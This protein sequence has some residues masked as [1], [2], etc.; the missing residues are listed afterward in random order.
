NEKNKQLERYIESNLQLENFAHLASHD[1]REPM[2][3][4]VSFSQ[5]LA[6]SGRSKLDKHEL[7]YLDFIQQGTGRIESLVQDLLAY[8]TISHSPLSLST[9]SAPELLEEVKTD[10][11]KLLADKKGKIIIDKIPVEIVADRSRIYQLFQNLFTNALRY[12][13]TGIAPE[14]RVSTLEN[15]NS[16]HFQVS[17]NGK[18]IAP[19]FHEQIFILFKSLENKSATNSSGIGLATCRKIAEDHQGKIWVESAVGQG[20]TFHFTIAKGFD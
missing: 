16:Y 7:E 11:T 14:I 3:N 8:S 20:S 1:L 4:I 12:G 10:I 5:L 6:K 9:F 19:Q 17:D 18:G 2:R 15:S 13:Q